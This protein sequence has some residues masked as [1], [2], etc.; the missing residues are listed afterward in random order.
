MGSISGS[1]R[2]LRAGSGVVH[3]TALLR[4]AAWRVGLGRLAGVEDYR[5]VAVAI[6]RFA[7]QLQRP[8]SREKKNLR[9]LCE[10]SNARRVSDVFG[11]YVVPYEVAYV[12]N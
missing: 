6:K 4:V 2:G 12:W 3:G 11:K 5:T 1:V 7:K 10:M 9:K 8:S